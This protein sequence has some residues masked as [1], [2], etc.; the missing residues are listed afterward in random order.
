MPP[1]RKSIIHTIRISGFTR[2]NQETYEHTMKVFKRFQLILRI[3]PFIMLGV[4]IGVFYILYAIAGTNFPLLLL[5][6]IFA[7]MLIKEISTLL[8]SVSMRKSILHPLGRL[9]EAVDEVSKGNYGYTIDCHGASMVNDLIYSFNRMSLELKEA[10]DMKRKYESNRKE[11]IAGISHD[12]KTPITSILGYVNGIQSGVADSEEKLNNYLNIIASNAEYT[13]RLIDELFLFSKLD[14]NQMDYQFESVNLMDFFSDII[15]EKQLELE[16]R[17]IELTYNLSIN[18]DDHLELDAKMI[19]R[20]LSNLISNAIKYSDKEK[21]TIHIE[22]KHIDANPNGIKVSVKDNGKGISAN[23]MDNIFDV[24]YRADAARNKDIGGSG[25]GLAIAR[26]LIMAHDGRIWVESEYGEGS[27]F[28]FT[29]RESLKHTTKTK[30]NP[31][32]LVR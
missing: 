3:F 30:V 20:V 12:L 32:N 2:E 18:A 13:N 21:T 1:Q 4:L 17:G 31:T 14:I 5:I 6:F 8:F 11:L 16:D 28:H 23:Q 15:I 22:V 27:T 24:F 19:Y 9:K 26:E 10:T 29:L 25:L 7:I